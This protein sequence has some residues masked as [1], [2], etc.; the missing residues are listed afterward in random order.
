[1][2]FQYIE[3]PSIEKIQTNNYSVFLA[4]GITNCSLWQD[5]MVEALKQFDHL[6]VFNPRRKNFEMFKDESKYKES[7]EQITWEY[8]NLKSVSQIIF[9]FT[10]ETLQP[11]TLF[12]LGTVLERWVNSSSYNGEKQDL[13]IGCDKK[14]PR[15]FDVMIQ[16]QLR[17]YTTI[18]DNF[19]DLVETVQIFQKNMKKVREVYKI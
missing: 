18:I 5:K 3:A 9:W 14:Y 2:S 13:I 19:D 15:Y 11:I 8:E 10:N 7:V 16:C 17:G 6:T 1:M 12:E 4:G